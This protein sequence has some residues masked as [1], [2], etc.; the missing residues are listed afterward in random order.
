MCHDPRSVKG[1]VPGSSTAYLPRNAIPPM[2]AKIV[3]QN[4]NMKME[5]RIVKRS[6][7]LR[8]NILY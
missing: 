8:F 4:A 3:A 6:S 5:S 1:L 2:M 7:S